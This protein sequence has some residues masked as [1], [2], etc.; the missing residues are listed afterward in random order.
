MSVAID[1]QAVKQFL[2]SLQ[3]DICTQLEQ[4]DGKARFEQDAWQRQPGERLAG[5]GR[6]RVMTNGA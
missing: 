2:M 3:D 6:T 5:G 4:A 1:K